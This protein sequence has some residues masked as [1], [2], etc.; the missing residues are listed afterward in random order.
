MKKQV[1]SLL[2]TFAV[3]SLFVFARCKNSIPV[4][5]VKVCDPSTC[6]AGLGLQCVNDECM[7]QSGKVRVSGFGCQGSDTTYIGIGKSRV[8]K[9]TIILSFNKTESNQ[10]YVQFGLSFF[11]V[12]RHPLGVPGVN[13][14]W[15]NRIH[16]TERDSIYEYGPSLSVYELDGK[17]VFQ[18]FSGRILD[19][20]TIRL[21]AVLT[22]RSNGKITARLD[23]TTY[24][25]K[26]VN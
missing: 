4:Q 15:V 10:N 2:F 25:F 7:C 19:D 16:D 5:P 8:W 17:Y 21:K 9:D 11:D 18:E 12:T 3:F 1:K 24:I 22:T 20:K 23:S 6:S 14:V 26:K 13:S